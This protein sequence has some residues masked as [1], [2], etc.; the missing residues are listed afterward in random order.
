MTKEA[1]RKKDSKM[2][3]DMYPEGQVSRV[4]PS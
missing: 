2:V 4:S 1:E 3:A